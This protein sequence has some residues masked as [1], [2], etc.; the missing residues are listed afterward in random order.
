MRKQRQC[1]RHSGD[2]HDFLNGGDALGGLVE[3]VLTQRLHARIPRGAVVYSFF[4]IRMYPAYRYKSLLLSLFYALIF[5]ATWWTSLEKIIR[6]TSR[7]EPQ[8]A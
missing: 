6:I 4:F 7:E 8:G 5:L 1:P 2:P 3:A